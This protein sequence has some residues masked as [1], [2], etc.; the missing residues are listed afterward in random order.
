[1]K[2][3]AAVRDVARAL[4]IPLADANKVAKLIPAT[5]DMTLDKA[6]QE[7][8][9]LKEL[10]RSDPRVKELLDVARRLEGMARHASTHAA[11]VVIAPGPITD[12]RRGRHV[13][14]LYRS[15][16]D[17]CA[18]RRKLRN[19]GHRRLSRRGAQRLFHLRLSLEVHLGHSVEPRLSTV[20]AGDKSGE[21]KT[22]DARDLGGERQVSLPVVL[23]EGFGS[24]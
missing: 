16:N 19:V 11:G 2:A 15:H 17:R 22:R 8:P 13:L 4:D 20:R 10:E 21:L 9:A 14:F 24:R 18:A 6:V 1:M 3:K 12:Y 23:F 5:L 7:T